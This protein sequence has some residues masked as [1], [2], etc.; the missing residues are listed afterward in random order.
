MPEEGKLKL[1]G[2]QRDQPPAVSISYTANVGVNVI[3][4][5]LKVSSYGPRPNCDLDEYWIGLENIHSL[6][7]T[8]ALLKIDLERYNGQSGTVEYDNFVVGDRRSNYQLKSVGTF[9]ND[10]THDIGMLLAVTDCTISYNLTDTGEDTLQWTR[11]FLLL[12]PTRP[13]D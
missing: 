4:K 1:N 11:Y 5:V 6:T 2:L 13:S 3:E 7:S 10:R 9:R 8:G 12:F